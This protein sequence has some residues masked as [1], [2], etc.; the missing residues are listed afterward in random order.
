MEGQS[1]HAIN[2]ERIF[3]SFD[4]SRDD[5]ALSGLC[6]DLLAQQKI[7]WLLLRDAYAAQDAA[8]I[9]EISANGFSVKL[10]F[11]PRRIISSAAAVDPASISRRPC[12]LCVENLPEEQ[13][14]ILYRQAFL[15][16]CNPAPIF[17]QHYVVSNR[18]H[19]PQSIENNMASFLLLAKDFGPGLS[20]FYNGPRCGASAP[21]HLHFH[22][23]P[24]DMMPIEKEIREDRNKILIRRLNGMSILTLM[25]LSRPVI[26]V[27][28]KELRSVETALLKAVEAMR[29]TLS[30]PD[31]P[32]MNL[33]CAYDGTQWRI[34]IFPR[35]KH[36][37]DAY[38]REGDERILISPGAVDMGGLI[39][40]PVEKDFHALD[41]EQIK[42]IF[43]EV[44]MDENTFTSV[45]VALSSRPDQ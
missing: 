43:K 36:R 45:V 32:M 41:A 31:E 2:R 11:N 1:A 4:G 39:I 29:E 6:L 40:T 7:S 21:D 30:A 9:R 16:L 34:L 26:I 15:I 5:P 18:R 23:V 8:Q 20:V 42:H 37:P 3:A 13:K 17:P 25:S 12:F 14:M 35:R 28:G 19:I 27:E 10:Q 44:S 22:V 38:Y 33:L 24:S